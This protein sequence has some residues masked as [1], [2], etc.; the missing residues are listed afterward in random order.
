[1]YTM[2]KITAIVN[3]AHSHKKFLQGLDTLLEHFKRSHN[4]EM[5]W[6]ESGGIELALKS[7]ISFQKKKA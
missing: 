3:Q 1:M 5:H 2:S 6:W 7:V 4:R